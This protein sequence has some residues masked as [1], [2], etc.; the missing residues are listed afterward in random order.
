MA[1]SRE[2]EVSPAT[3]GTD[4]TLLRARSRGGLHS[5]GFAHSL[6]TWKDEPSGVRFQGAF[7]AS[8]DREMVPPKVLSYDAFRVLSFWGPWRAL[9]SSARHAT[10]LGAS[11]FGARTV[12]LGLVATLVG[13][14]AHLIEE[15]VWLPPKCGRL[16]IGCKQ[17]HSRSK[18][19]IA[20]P[21]SRLS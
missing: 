11:H 21:V 5:S 6:E 1:D 12:A 8:H 7:S 18:H 17:L 3:D 13:S 20:L 15:Q 9:F 14:A 10:T 16:A 19:T 4:D 2:D